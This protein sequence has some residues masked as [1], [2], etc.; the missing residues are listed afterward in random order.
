LEVLDW[1]ASNEMFLD[2]ALQ[3]LRSTGVIPNS[4]RVNYSNRPLDAYAQAVS[5]TAVY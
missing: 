5:F 1:S 3:I 4:F 2:D